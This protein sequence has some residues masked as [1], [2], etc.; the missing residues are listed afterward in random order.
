[1]INLTL[2]GSCSN[3]LSLKDVEVCEDVF[4]KPRSMFAARVNT[5]SAKN[6]F[7]RNLSVSTERERG[8]SLKPGKTL[9]VAAGV[10]SGARVAAAVGTQCRGEIV[11]YVLMSYPLKVP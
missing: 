5:V 7:A 4:H 6:P 3:C 9:R 8:D 2:A 10:G 1:M 11:G